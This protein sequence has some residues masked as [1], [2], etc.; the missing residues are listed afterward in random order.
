MFAFWAQ[1]LAPNLDPNTLGF[2]AVDTNFASCQNLCTHL[3]SPCP[4]VCTMVIVNKTP[5]QQRI[6]IMNKTTRTIA[7]SAALIFGTVGLTGVAL[8]D[9][10]QGAADDVDV[11][12]VQLADDGTVEDDTNNE[13]R[14]GR[15]GNNGRKLAL[16]AETIGIE[17]DELREGLQDDQSIAEIAEEN[18]VAAQDVIDAMIDRVEEKLD[19]KVAEGDLTEEEAAEKL[20]AKTERIEDRVNGVDDDDAEAEEVNA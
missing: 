6:E 4:A 16:V 10:P 14:S 13:G 9:S 20:E 5:N 7:A 17:V 12:E 15:R 1:K 11:V 19:A 2:A 8:A 3:R 18:G